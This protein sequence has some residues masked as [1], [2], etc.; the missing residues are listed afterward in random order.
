MLEKSFF[1]TLKSELTHHK[2]NNQHESK[3]IIFEYI[4]VFHNRIRI[5]SANNYLAPSEFKR[6]GLELRKY[7][8]SA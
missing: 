3:N 4:E 7:T 8:K 6:R 1:K 2:F 5:H